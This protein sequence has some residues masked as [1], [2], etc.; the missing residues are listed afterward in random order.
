MPRHIGTVINNELAEKLE[1]LAQT[2]NKTVYQLV[3]EL[4]EEHVMG[5]GREEKNK[6]VGSSLRKDPPR[7]EKK[8]SPTPSVG[9]IF[10]ASIPSLEKVEAE[11]KEK[12]IVAETK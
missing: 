8:R 12:G 11:V 9:L 6:S 4:I 10:R 2:E 3:K 7:A 5:E 1:A